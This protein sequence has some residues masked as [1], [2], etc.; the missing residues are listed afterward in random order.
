M[1]SQATPIELRKLLKPSSKVLITMHKGPDGDAIGSSLGFQHFLKSLGVIATVVAPDHY[2][3]FLSWL[4]G[5]EEVIVAE[6]HPAKAKRALD[7]C[8]VV[9]CLDFNHP[10]RLGSFEEFVTQSNKTKVVVD[11]H[12]DPSDFGDLY[13]VDSEASSTAEMIYR[14]VS[15]FKETHLISKEMAICLYTGLVTD[16]GSFRFSSVTPQVM[17]IAADLMDTGMDHVKVY[18]EVFD[19]STLDR[20]RLRG[21]ALSQKTEVIKGTGAAYIS[22]TESELNTFNY[23]RG[24]TEG[25]VNYALSIEGVHVAGFFYERDGHVKLSLRSKGKIEVNRVA[26]ALFQGGGHKMA[27]GG[28][29]DEGLDS[30]VKKFI[31]AAQAGFEMNTVGQ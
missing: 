17:R 11:H 25:L 23:Q 3:K 4:P 26:G 5:S 13:F 31:E 19:N 20:L 9:F 28:R 10:S 27:A 24:D 12:Q 1:I 30:A 18:N 2:P 14:L 15:G 29:S 7:D 16:T 8:D 6:A 22:L 21:Y